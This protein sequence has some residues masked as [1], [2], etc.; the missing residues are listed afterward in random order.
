MHLAAGDLCAWI[1][2]DAVIRARWH[3]DNESG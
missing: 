1:C 2:A 3:A